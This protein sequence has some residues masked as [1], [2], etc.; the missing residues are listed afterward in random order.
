MMNELNEEQKKTFQNLQKPTMSLIASFYESPEEIK[1]VFADMMAIYEAN[2]TEETAK[3]LSDKVMGRENIKDKKDW[4]QHAVASISPS[5]RIEAKKKYIDE[6]RAVP[7]GVPTSGMLLGGFD[8]VSRVEKDTLMEAQ[9]AARLISHINVLD[10]YQPKT[11]YQNE[12]GSFENSFLDKPFAT[13]M[14][15]LEHIVNSVVNDIYTAVKEQSNMA[16]DE[17]VCQETKRLCRENVFFQKANNEAVKTLYDCASKLK[18]KAPEVSEKLGVLAAFWGSQENQS[19]QLLTKADF[20]KL[21]DDVKNRPV[22]GLVDHRTN[23]IIVM[24]QAQ[25]V[26]LLSNKTNG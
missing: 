26:A 17:G 21:K 18:D 2:P 10:K 5:I 11:N 4:I 7:K 20:D 12:D 24:E 14:Q 25:R 9:A 23:Q 13:R 6:Q 8:V 1:N 15:R 19:Q 22:F 3:A 16:D